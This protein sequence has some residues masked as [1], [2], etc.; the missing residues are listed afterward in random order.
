M[1][2]VTAILKEA[3]EYLANRIEPLTVTLSS[4]PID[5]ATPKEKRKTSLG[6]V[7]DFSY[8]GEGVRI[9]NTLPGS[10]AQQA[11]LQPGD[12]LI[13]LAGQPVSDLASYAAILRTLR[14]REKVELQFR[15]DDEIKVVEVVLV[16]R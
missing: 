1:V 10:P 13:Q 9:D 5:S 6:T 12:I 16:E 15:R 14:A 8:Q 3:T 2:K 11:G 7:S 4:A